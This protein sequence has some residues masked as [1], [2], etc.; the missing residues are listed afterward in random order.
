MPVCDWKGVYL[1]SLL[2]V[3]EYGSLYLPASLLKKTVYVNS[4]SL[5]SDCSMYH[6]HRRFLPADLHR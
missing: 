1:F 4:S 2:S 3:K 6:Q 5:K